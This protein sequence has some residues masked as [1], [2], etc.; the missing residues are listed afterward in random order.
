M[1]LLRT[2]LPAA[3]LLSSLFANADSTAPKDPE[4]YRAWA[5]QL[6]Q[7]MNRRQGEVQLPN[8]VATLTVPQQFYYLEPRD[9][10]KVLVDLWGNPRGAGTLGMLVPADITPMDADSWA[11]TISY[12]EEGYIADKDAADIDYA[13]LL[14]TMQKDSKEANRERQAQG[15]PAV[16]LVGWAA[17]PHYDKATHKLYWAKELKFG[18]QAQHTLNYNIRILGRKGVLVL[19]FIADMAQKQTIENRLNQVLAMTNFNSGHRYEEF[20]PGIDKVAA[21]GIG[22]LIAGKVAAKAGLFAAA[23]LF[24]KKFGILIVAGLGALGSRLFKRGQ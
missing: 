2:L 19:N 24:L 17:P 3:L 10:E 9:A 6:W 21:Y 11:V 1:S 7:S 5:L 14:R 12:E 18:D 15:Y 23:L 20:N 13:E 22:A 4:Q 8:G 16:E